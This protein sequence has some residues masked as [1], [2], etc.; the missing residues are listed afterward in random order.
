MNLVK[1]KVCSK[2]GKIKVARAEGAAKVPLAD[3]EERY[4]LYLIAVVASWVLE[5]AIQMVSVLSGMAL[6]KG[7]LTLE[8]HSSNSLNGNELGS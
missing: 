8:C 2:H 5:C 1:K 3:P 4:H 6:G 7:P